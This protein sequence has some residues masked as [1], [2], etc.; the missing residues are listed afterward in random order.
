MGSLEV[1]TFKLAEQW[2]RK[3]WRA[4]CSYRGEE[5][6]SWSYGNIL[7]MPQRSAVKNYL[8]SPL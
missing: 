8:F 3:G 1:W 6:K 4:W 5:G 2:C 7:A